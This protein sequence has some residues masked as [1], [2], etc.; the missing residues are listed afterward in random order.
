MKFWIGPYTYLE[1]ESIEALEAYL[2]NLQRRDHAVYAVMIT[3][4]DSYSNGCLRLLHVD[5]EQYSNM[6][7]A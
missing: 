3:L 2:R 6:G 7:H 4:P 5:N 1:V